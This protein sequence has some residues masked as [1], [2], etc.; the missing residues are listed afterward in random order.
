MK[1]LVTGGAGFIGFHLARYLA[2]REDTV[3]VSDNLSRGEADDD[4][5]RLIRRGNVKF[6]RADLTDREELRELGEGYDLV[7]HLAAING[8]RYF[9]EVPHQVLR[10]N[11]LSLINVL[12]WVSTG[13]GRKVIWTSSSEVY[14]GTV[15]LGQAPIP[16]PEDVALAIG[17]ISNPRFSYAASK[18]AGESLCLHYA[19]AYELPVTIVRPHN[20]YG[21]RMG[22]DHVIPQFITRILQR[23]DPFQV[24]GGEQ[25]RAFCFVE[26]LVKGLELVGE[27][28]AAEG[29]IINLGNDHEQVRIADLA[30]K[31]F[32]LFGFHPRLKRLPAPPGSVHRRCPDIAK[33][34]RL[35]GYG[36]EVSLEVGLQ[37]TYGWYVIRG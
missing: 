21:P 24:F 37:R 13:G 10:N 8:T 15:S 30:H 26:D 32:D 9:Y 28:R 31:M 17:D 18:I 16:T 33:A 3:V 23:Q 34:R 12:D 4:F 35:V 19:R 36:A 6:V 29:E 14:A 5:A 7:Y 25:S 2:D 11:L 27:S 1:I 22:Y 20:I